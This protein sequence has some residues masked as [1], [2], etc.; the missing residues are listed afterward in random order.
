MHIRPLH[1]TWAVCAVALTTAGLLT[2]CSNSSADE[3]S[4]TAGASSDSAAFPV[5][6][7]HA[8]GET[9][10][11]EEPTRIVVAGYTEQDTVLALGVIPVGVTEWY[12]DQPF[13][14]WPWA[15]AAL[16]DAE[17][18]VL[19]NDDGFETEKIAALEPDLIIATNAGLTAD[20]YDTLSDIAPTLAQSD[21]A[22]AYFEPW[23][24]QAD[25][26]GR[27]LGKKT[28]V[29]ALIDGVNQKFADAAAAHP[30][31]AGKKAIFLQN[32]FY[33][34][35]AIAYQDGLSTDF[36]T[37][38]GFV[39]P[40]DIDAYVPA[41]GS[42][43]AS[44][45]LENLSVLNAADVLIW[46]TEEPGDRTELEKEAVYGAL[47]PVQDGTL[48]FTDGVTAGAIYFTSVLSLPYVIDRLTPALD[49]ALGGTP[50]TITG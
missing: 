45:P 36:L 49:E 12:G 5:T 37:E 47:E 32:A 6:I 20:T 18:E 28:E 31:F 4:P 34:G 14:T 42:A 23:D 22:T 41:D 30:E 7:E 39:I 16:G 33:E 48:V 13:A 10:V 44:I 8:F 21:A 50:A 40:D 3:A 29:D 38:L 9:V 11:P 43:Q 27:A 19:S 17:P 46:G 26:I 35:K 2:A 1:R 24:I 25:K 15:Q